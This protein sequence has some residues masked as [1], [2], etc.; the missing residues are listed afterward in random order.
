[1]PRKAVLPAPSAATACSAAILP[2]AGLWSDQPHAVPGRVYEVADAP[3]TA[4]RRRLAHPLATGGLDF[5]KLRLDIP[6][7]DV[8]HSGH[9]RRVRME[10]AAR[11]RAGRSEEHTSE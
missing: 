1:M 11:T 6:R 8:R 5:R 3:G 2:A 4:H 10:D 9:G 7:V